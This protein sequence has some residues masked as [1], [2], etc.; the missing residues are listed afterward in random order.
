MKTKTKMTFAEAVN[1]YVHRYTIDH[2]PEWAKHAAP[3]GKYY[4]PQYRSDTEWFKNTLF[5]PDNP[6]GPRVTDCYSTGQTWPVGQWL[7]KPFNRAEYLKGSHL[8]TGNL[9]SEQE[10]L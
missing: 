8:W 7:D 1:Q 9:R 10:E 3:N 5:P 6:L 2:M 4:A